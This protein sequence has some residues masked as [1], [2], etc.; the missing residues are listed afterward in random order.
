MSN[1]INC[2]DARIRNFSR[3]PKRYKTKMDG[4]EKTVGGQRQFAS[5]GRQQ[6]AVEGGR[7]RRVRAQSGKTAGV[8][9]QKRIE[10]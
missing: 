3:R 5:F 4:P 10:A 7:C 1:Y 8:L 2:L 6:R 9:R